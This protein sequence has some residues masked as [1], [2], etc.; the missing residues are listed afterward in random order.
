MQTI[1]KEFH[2]I[3]QAIV[4]DDVHHEADTYEALIASVCKSQLF[5]KF[6]AMDAVR[7]SFDEPL[8]DMDLDVEAFNEKVEL[9]VNFVNSLSFVEGE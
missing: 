6:R 9:E 2:G 7:I 4:N 3:Y 5:E 8:L 1:P